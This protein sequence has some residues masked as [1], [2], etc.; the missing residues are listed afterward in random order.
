MKNQNV[1]IT[2]IDTDKNYI[3]EAV[4]TN[5]KKWNVSHIDMKE[6]SLGEF[7]F[8]TQSGQSE[9]YLF[10]ISILCFCIGSALFWLLLKQAK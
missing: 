4:S 6:I 8:S 2:K 1:R 9:Y 7:Y 3:G 5:G 10:I